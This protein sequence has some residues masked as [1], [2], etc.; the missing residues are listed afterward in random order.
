MNGKSD[1]TKKKPSKKALTAWRKNLMK[2]EDKQHAVW[3]LFGA[4]FTLLI[5]LFF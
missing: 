1:N 4:G 5:Y 3:F 2:A